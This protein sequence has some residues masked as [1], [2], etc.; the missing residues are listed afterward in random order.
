MISL[1]VSLDRLSL[2]N[3][4]PIPSAVQTPRCDRLGWNPDGYG[5][6]DHTVFSFDGYYYIAS[7]RLPG[8]MAFAYARSTDLCHW[9]D[10]GPIL[11]ARIAGEWDETVIWAPYVLE[12]NGI[13]YMYYTGVRRG[14]TQS[15]MLATTINPADPASWQRQGMIFQPNHAGAVW[16]SGRWA[17]CRD[18]SVFKF[19]QVYYM[20][21]TGRDVTGSIIGWATSV[22]P[23]GPWHDWG[24]TLTLPRRGTMAESPTIFSYADTYYLVYNNTSMGEEYRIGSTPTGPWSDAV[25]FPAGWAN[26]VWVG[27]NGQ[28]YTS[29]VNNY[30]IVIRRV[31]VN[32]TVTSPRLL[33]EGKPH[34]LFFPFMVNP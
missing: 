2:K 33:V 16:K 1:P 8:E 34:R 3:A 24:A 10:L 26:E 32:E 7:I 25:S 27:Q 13:Y 18:A 12:D 17:D 5:L 22:S 4:S 20:Y 31:K 30:A 21:Y 29:Y 6:K 14:Y 23:V 19:H 11:N 15:I 9:E 28:E